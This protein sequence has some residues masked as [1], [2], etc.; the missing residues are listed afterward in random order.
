MPKGYKHTWKTKQLLRKLKLGKKLLPEHRAKVIKTLSSY[1]NQLGDKNPN[2]KGGRITVYSDKRKK[3]DRVKATKGYIWLRLP[4][5]PKAYKG[6]YYPEH[7]YILEQ[8]MGRTLKRYEHVHH[9]NGVKDDNR[10]ENL[11]LINAQ[12]HNLVSRLESR[13]KELEKENKQLKL[14]KL[15]LKIGE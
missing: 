15:K 9:I 8:K 7:R 1:G 2:W 13:I 14:L 12:T 6:G 11:E 4:N 3:K 10:P 5:H